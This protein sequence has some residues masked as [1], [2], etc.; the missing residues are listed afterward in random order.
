MKPELRKE[1]YQLARKVK[2]NSK[3]M[4]EVWTEFKAIGDRDPTLFKE[5]S[6][7]MYGKAQFAAGYAAAK[8]GNKKSSYQ[9]KDATW[10]VNGKKYKV[11]D[12]KHKRKFK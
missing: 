6:K 4:R 8:N 10:T 12:G 1:L 3:S 9:K 11:S 2:T 7:I 5:F